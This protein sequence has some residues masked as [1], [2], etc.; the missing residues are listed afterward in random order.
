MNF[1]VFAIADIAKI[2]AA[3]REQTAEY[4]RWNSLYNE[5]NTLKE[6]INKK[7]HETQVE[8]AGIKGSIAQIIVLKQS[9]QWKLAMLNNT[10][11]QFN[12][13]ISKKQTADERLAATIDSN[14]RAIVGK[15]GNEND[16][17]AV[18]A[19]VEKTNKARLEPVLA[20]MFGDVEQTKNLIDEK[21]EQ[22]KQF[23]AEVDYVLS[24]VNA[25]T[26]IEL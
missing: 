25:T 18:Y 12:S 1:D 13:V 8:I 11:A 23:I 15:E 2:E 22:I 7:N 16:Y 6:L 19:D 9:I 20:S 21:I 24:E 3:K 14:V 5:F 26:L 4:D 17:E 10:R